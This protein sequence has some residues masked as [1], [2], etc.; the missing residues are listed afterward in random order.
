MIRQLPWSTLSWITGLCMLFFGQ[1]VL[2]GEGNAGIVSLIGLLLLGAAT[3][4]QAIGLRKSEDPNRAAVHRLLALAGTCGLVAILLFLVSIETSLDSGILQTVWPLLLLLSTCVLVMVEVSHVMASIVVQPRRIAHVR[5]TAILTGLAIALVFP[6]NYLAIEKNNRWDLTYF[7]TS[8]AGSATLGLVGSLQDPV[9]VRIFQEPG[10]ETIG[11][12]RAYFEPLEGPMLSVEILD[13]AAEPLLVEELKIPDNGYV[14]VSLEKTTESSEDPDESPVAAPTESFQVSENWDR[15]K[16]TLKVLDGKFY[17]TLAEVVKGA[18][19]LY[20]TSGHREMALRGGDNP[21]LRFK[22][23]SEELKSRGFTVKTLEREDLLDSVPNDAAAV[24]ILGPRDPFVEA[25]LVQLQEFKDSGGSL[26]I[27]LRPDMSEDD[28]SLAPLL[29]LVGIEQATG[30]LADERRIIPTP[31]FPRPRPSDRVNIITGTFSSHPITTTLSETA[32][33][34]N[35]GILFPRSSALTQNTDFEGKQT[36]A[37]RST[38]TN[39]MDTNSNLLFDEDAEE[40][41]IRNLATA[42]EG[43]GQE[44]PWKAVVFSSTDAFSDFWVRL[45]P[46][47]ALLMMDSTAWLTGGDNDDAGFGE[48]EDEKDPVIVHRTEDNLKWF[49]GTVFFIPLLVFVAGLVR[50]RS[51]QGGTIV[52]ARGDQ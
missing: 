5:D 4:R 26:M 3:V 52:I 40:K 36:V 11:E 45:S 15:A 48:I 35:A 42:I 17:R 33:S 37:L 50:L 20:M 38:A 32:G 34:R 1:R 44:G 6:L 41:S 10:S 39:W 46:G 27:T 18:R 22:L 43:D 29:D 28:S 8:E 49:Y 30:V 13:H 47:A 31:P 2:I 21:T 19:V 25:E 23:I 16:K 12:L 14:A 51:R 9:T 7:K 24:L